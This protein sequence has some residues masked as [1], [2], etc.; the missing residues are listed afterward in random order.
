MAALRRLVAQSLP[1]SSKSGWMLFSLSSA[2]LGVHKHPS[3]PLRPSAILTFKLLAFVSEKS[4]DQPT[5]LG[6]GGL[7]L[8]LIS[9]MLPLCSSLLGM[10]PSSVTSTGAGS[11][12]CTK[13]TLIASSPASRTS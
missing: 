13:R 5:S 4:V 7:F 2:L 9:K 3:R 6:S 11:S 10:T 1:S 8:C 12:G